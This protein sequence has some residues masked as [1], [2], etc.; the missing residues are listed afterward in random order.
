MLDATQKKV[1]GWAIVI[2]LL[3]QPAAVMGEAMGF[4]PNPLGKAWINFFNPSADNETVTLSARVDLDVFKRDTTTTPSGAGYIGY[5]WN[6]NG[7][8]EIGDKELGEGEIEK[9]TFSSGAFT[10]S[11]RYPADKDLYIM[12]PSSQN[13]GYETQTVI[14]QV[15]SDAF[16][17]GRTGNEAITVGDVFLTLLED[18]ITVTVSEEDAG[19]LVTSSTDYNYTTY[20]TTAKMTVKITLGTDSSGIGVVDYTDW[21]DWDGSPAKYK[22]TFIG[23]KMDAADSGNAVFSSVSGSDDQGDYSYYWWD[24]NEL[25]MNTAGS[26]DDGT[27]KLEFT[28]T[29][30]GAF[31]LNSIGIYNEVLENEFGQQAWGTADGEETDIDFT[32]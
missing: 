4:L 32:A 8:I 2:I 22:G 11:L 20:G 7:I 6:K 13:S 1:L 5:D 21:S 30:I 23:I 3:A 19:T 27:Y 17:P 26:S 29:V 24:V 14:R 16:G 15:P 18:T 12:F 10:S 25:I 9:V 28:I 31:D